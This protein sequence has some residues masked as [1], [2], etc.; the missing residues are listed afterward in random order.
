MK[1]NLLVFQTAGLILK[2]KLNSG[3]VECE[4]ANHVLQLV[5]SGLTGFRWPFANFAN[6]QAPSADIF[7]TFWTSVDA[8]Y[9]WGFQP[10]YS[11]L[12]GSA[13]NRALS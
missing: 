6:T 11:S 7:H 1:Q 9:N 4:L 8:L 3:K 10:I 13:Y 2:Q 5:F 12:D